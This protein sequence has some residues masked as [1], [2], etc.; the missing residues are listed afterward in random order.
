MTLE[1][2][3]GTVSQGSEDSAAMSRIRRDM[4]PDPD[5]NISLIFAVDSTGI[6]N[7][8]WLLMLCP[9]AEVVLRA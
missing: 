9:L 2:R 7:G 5:A 6:N 3:V 4:M 1:F 8:V